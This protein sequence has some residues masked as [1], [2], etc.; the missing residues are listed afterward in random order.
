[1]S[2]VEL[3][4]GNMTK[5]KPVYE[6]LARKYRPRQFSDVVGQQHVTKTLANA[7]TANRIA[8]A[9]LLV[10]PRGIGKT[11]IARIFSKALNCQ[12]GP[13]SE[14]CDQCD[15]C[16]EIA[17]GRSLD[18]LEIDG[19]SNNGVE[20]IRELRDNVQYAA[21]RGPF[22]VYII[23]EVHMLSISAFNAL[24]KTLEEPPQHVKFIFATTEPQKVP[25]TIASRC[26]RF[27]L[28][29]ITANDIIGQLKKIAV[30]ENISVDDEA[31]FAIARG[32]EGGMRDAESTFDQLISFCGRTIA[33]SDVLSVFGLVSRQSLESLAFAILTGDITGLLTSLSELDRNG[34]DLQRVVLEL[35]E[36]FRNVLVVQ[37]GAGA[38]GALDL[39]DRQMETLRNHAGQL[40]SSQLLRIVELLIETESRLRLTVSRRTLL[41][42]S[43]IRCARTATTVSIESVIRQ[44][45]V[46]KRSLGV[47][48]TNPEV[49][50]P[51][52][53]NPPGYPP[54]ENPPDRVM[55]SPRFPREEESGDE[56]DVPS[57]ADPVEASIAETDLERLDATWP[58]LVSEI[59]RVLPRLA[60]MLRGSRVG[61]VGVGSVEIGI[62][63]TRAG[64]PGFL[65]DP[66]NRLV[67]EQAIQRRFGVALSAQ[68]IP[69]PSTPRSE[70]NPVQ[71]PETTS[72]SD[73]LSK[74][75]STLR[76]IQKF[77][78]TIKKDT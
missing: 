39:P 15:S 26:Q 58:E 67:I 70:T 68:M 11:S 12:K 16:L 54:A 29:R 25:A 73:F 2:L 19:A 13:T 76:W 65:S 22:K 42:S 55:E 43:L 66:R 72:A 35:L 48:D 38:A 56:P 60:A 21:A 34:K 33:E 4:M 61:R 51:V 30:L 7:I 36:H 75:P 49:S 31:L 6:V 74:D 47:P 52:H 59:G 32:A 17:A 62:D 23:D 14:P 41:E 71:K 1:M 28:R 5:E 37:Q 78:G 53:R 45:A 50:Q 18:V 77:N 3:R 57:L 24:L 9:Y 10:G 46:L 69:L 63:S 20:Q 40:D 27:D 44:L 64:D 8:H